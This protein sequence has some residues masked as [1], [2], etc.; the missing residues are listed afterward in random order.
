MI[1]E[2]GSL[3]FVNCESVERS[4]KGSKAYVQNQM[5]RFNIKFDKHK[6]AKLV[7]QHQILQE[8]L[9]YCRYLVER[10]ENVDSTEYL[11]ESYPDFLEMS[12]FTLS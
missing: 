7:L 9:T 11:C 5:S 2:T 1:I 8:E 10:I 12:S 6:I 3:K 4:M